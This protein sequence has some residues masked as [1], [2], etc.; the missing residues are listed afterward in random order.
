MV[1]SQLTDSEELYYS[2]VYF[3]GTTYRKVLQKCFR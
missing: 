2:Y 3:L 1:L